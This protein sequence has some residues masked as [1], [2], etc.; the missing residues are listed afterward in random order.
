MFSHM[1]F[2]KKYK[3]PVVRTSVAQGLLLLVG[4]TILD[5]GNFL[6]TALIAAAAYWA[7]LLIVVARHP[8]VPSKGDLIWAKGD[9]RLP[10]PWHLPLARSFCI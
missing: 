9:M 8:L 2:S 4:G 10:R 6:F 1:T 5:G 7:A 3:E